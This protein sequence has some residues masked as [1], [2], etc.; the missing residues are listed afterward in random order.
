METTSAEDI[1]ESDGHLR[2]EISHKKERVVEIS[3]SMAIENIQDAVRRGFR[4]LVDEMISLYVASGVEQMEAWH[5]LC[6][7]TESFENGLLV[8]LMD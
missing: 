8:T 7:V 4:N 2:K 3:T 1:N 6:A 5:R